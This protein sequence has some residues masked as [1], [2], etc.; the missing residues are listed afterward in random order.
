MRL[1]SSNVRT[2]VGPPYLSL[3]N[4]FIN[5]PFNPAIELVTPPLDG[6]ILPGVTRDSVLALARDHA[7]GKAK[8]PGLPDNLV[9][10][11]RSMT[12]KEVKKAAAEGATVWYLRQS[13]VARAARAW[14]GTNMTVI[15]S[16]SN[17]VHAERSTTTFVSHGPTSEDCYLAITRWILMARRVLD[18]S[19]LSGVRR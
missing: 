7:S 10:S 18:P 15:Y 5:A 17:S 16:A 2:E 3:F 14:Y 12:M 13:V 1:P 8:V 11:E 19:S 9:V 6:V 4:K